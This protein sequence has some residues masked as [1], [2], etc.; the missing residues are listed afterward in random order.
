MNGADS[1]ASLYCGPSQTKIVLGSNS[2]VSITQT[3]NYPFN[4]STREAERQN[5]TGTQTELQRNSQKK[6]D[7]RDIIDTYDTPYS[8]YLYLLCVDLLLLPLPRARLV[9]ERL[10]HTRTKQHSDKSVNRME[11]GSDSR[12][13]LEYGGDVADAVES[14]EETIGWNFDLQVRRGRRKQ[15]E[16]ERRRREGRDSQAD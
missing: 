14:A 15:R 10:C 6:S 4:D 1:V 16:R 9:S 8:G 11:Y 13:R 7:E 3:T 5:E 2:P 12:G